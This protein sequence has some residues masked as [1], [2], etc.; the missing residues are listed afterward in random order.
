M[1]D[2]A[3]SIYR[4][5][6]VI[7][8]LYTIKIKPSMLKKFMKDLSVKLN[9]TIIYGPVVKNLAENIN[10]VHKGYEC[11]LIWAQ[12]GTQVYTWEKNKFFTVDIYSC[13]KYD[14]KMATKFTKDFFEAKQIVSKNV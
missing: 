5:R 11:I 10:P 6:L 7:E 8:G 13:V 12:S 2:L 14:A 4:Q 3:P 9:M 1:K